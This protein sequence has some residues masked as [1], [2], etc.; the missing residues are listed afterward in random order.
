MAKV[1]MGIDPGE[2][3]GIAFFYGSEFDSSETVTGGVDGFISWWHRMGISDKIDEIVMEDFI[4][5]P[6]FVGRAEP[7]EIIGVVRAMWTGKITIQKRSDKATMFRQVFSGSKGEMER[8]AWL[9]ER[10]LHFT[11]GHEMD[12]ATHVLV[13]KKRDIKFWNKY[14]A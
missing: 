11:T 12:A 9:A 6:S 13:A 14:W 1:T 10:G 7:S 4:V 2:S 3:T 8:K 5:E